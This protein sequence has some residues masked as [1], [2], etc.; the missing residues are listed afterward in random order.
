M[1]D[2]ASGLASGVSGT[3]Q[4]V[5]CGVF[6]VAGVSKLR[7]VSDLRLTLARLGVGRTSFFA[8]ALI[9]SELGTVAGLAVRPAAAWPRFMVAVLALAFTAAGVRA[10]RSKREVTCACFGTLRGGALGWRQIGLLPLWL[11][12]AAIAQWHPPSWAPETGLLG[13]ASL[14]LVMA[15]REILHAAPTFVRLRGDRVAVA[16]SVSATPWSDS[17]ERSGAT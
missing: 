13:L 14:M 12:L 10:L 9:V 8:A 6:L 3:A 11:S 1:D 17:P 4:A 7:A 2:P 16:E 5:L 15:G